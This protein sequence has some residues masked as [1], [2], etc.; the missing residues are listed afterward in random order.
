MWAGGLQCPRPLRGGIPCAREARALRLPVEIQHSYPVA[1]QGRGGQLPRHK[2]RRC[3]GW[4]CLARPTPA[5]GACA[6]TSRYCYRYSLYPTR[7]LDAPF[8]SRSLVAGG[9]VPRLAFGKQLP[10]ELY[11][12]LRLFDA[13]FTVRRYHL[14]I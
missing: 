2:V 9:Y 4:H 3:V 7:Y 5:L 12:S 1:Q 13:L 6:R 8:N 11:F 14:I 10:Y